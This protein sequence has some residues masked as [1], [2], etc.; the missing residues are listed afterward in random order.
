MDLRLISHECAKKGTEM[1]ALLLIAAGYG[2]WRGARAAVNSVR[3]LP[4]TNDD[5]VFW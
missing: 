1:L 4:R 5:M 2:G 3:T